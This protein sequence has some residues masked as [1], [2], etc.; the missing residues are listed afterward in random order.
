MNKALETTTKETP[1]TQKLSI[2]NHSNILLH[3]LLKEIAISNDL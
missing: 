2:E 1:M 3:Q